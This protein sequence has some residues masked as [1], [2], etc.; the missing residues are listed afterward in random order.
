LSSSN[1]S[2]RTQFEASLPSKAVRPVSWS[3]VV[4]ASVGSLALADMSLR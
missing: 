1:S 2:R 4:S 3:S